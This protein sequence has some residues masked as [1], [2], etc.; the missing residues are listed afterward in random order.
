MVLEHSF[1]IQSQG[2]ARFLVCSNIAESEYFIRQHLALWRNE[3]VVSGFE[4]SLGLGVRVEVRF[5]QSDLTQVD[6]R[7]FARL[8]KSLHDLGSLVDDGVVL[9]LLRGGWLCLLL[10]FELSFLLFAKTL[11]HE[12]GRALA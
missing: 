3:V 7:H 12:G 10:D 4:M 11:D 2:Y 9:R 1:V 6:L 8:V 5:F